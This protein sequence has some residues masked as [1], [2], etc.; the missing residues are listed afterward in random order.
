MIAPHIG[1]AYDL[2]ERNACAVEIDET[3]VLPRVVNVLTGVFLHMNPRQT[4]SARAAVAVVDIQVAVCAQGKL[5]LADLI[6]FW[7]VGVKVVLARPAAARRNRAVRGEAGANS[8]PHHFAIE[9]GEHPREAGAYRTNVVIRRG[10]E[11]GRTA[12]ENLRLGQ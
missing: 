12:A 8:E 6:A 4:H 11:S 7:E 3:K 5:V 9:Y 2:Q 10:A 1:F